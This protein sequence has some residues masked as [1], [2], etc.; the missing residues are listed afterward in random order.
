M[1][2]ESQTGQSEAVHTD[3]I[4]Q[5]VTKVRERLAGRRRVLATY[6]LQF[7]GAQFR[8][9][10]G[11][12][13]VD[14]LARLGISHVYSSPIL[15]AGEGSTHGY[16]VVDH[17][18]LNDELGTDEEY[19]AYVGAL[20]EHG[21]GQIL[22]IVPNH[23]SVA[24]DAN[25]WWRDVLANGPAS[26]YA[27]YFDIDWRPVKRELRNRVLLPVLGDLYGKTLEAGQLPILLEEG[28]FYVQVYQRKLPLE[29]RTWV[30]ILEPGMEALT[31]KLNA[32]SLPLLEL[33]SIIRGLSYLPACDETAPD[34]LEERR[35]EQVV[36]QA[37]LQRLFDES[38]EIKEFVEG[39]IRRI[40]GEPGKPET[41]EALDRLLESQV[42]R[43]VLWRAGSDELNYRRFFD[44]TELA[45]VCTEHLDV[46]EA[47]H[48]LPFELLLRGD[49]D[50][51]RIDHVDGLFDPTEYLWRLQWMLLR[52]VTKQEFEKIAPGQPEK[53]QEIKQAVLGRLRGDV[54]GPDPVRLIEKAP[55]GHLDGADDA[56]TG[57]HSSKAKPLFVL[58][59]KILGVDEPLPSHWPVEGTSGYDF[60]NLLNGLF[61]DPDGL[62]Q[63]E[64]SWIRYTD[65]EEDLKDIV[66]HSKRLILSAAMQSEV[67]LLAH[68]LDR[69][70][71]RHRNT[72]DYTLQAIRSAIREIIASFPVYRTYIRRGLISERDRRVVQLATA[73]A[74]RRNPA[75]DDS[76]LQFVRDVLLLEQPPTLDEAGII[77]RY[78][79]IGRFQQVSSPVMAKGVEDTAFYRYVPLLSLEE[80]G[81][82]PAHG[83]LSVS[84]FHRQNSARRQEWPNAMLATSTHDTKRSEDVRARLD[85]LSEIPGEW[86]KA[87]SRWTRINKKFHRDVDGEPAP[88]RND[89]WLFYQS[90]VGVWPLRPPGAEERKILVERLQRY[91]EKA[92]REEKLNTSWISPNAAYDE[93]V[94]SFVADVMNPANGRFWTDFTAFHETVVDSGLIN[95]ASQSALKLTAPGIPD[96]YQGQELWDF[97]LVDPDNRRPVDYELRKRLLDDLISR[98]RDAASRL[99]LCKELIADP[100]DD[101]FKLLVH[102][103]LLQLRKRHPQL[104]LEGDYLPLAVEGELAEH[105]IAFARRLRSSD[106]S[107]VIVAP[108]LIHRLRGPE[109]RSPIGREVW[110]ETQIVIGDALPSQIVNQFTGST[111]SVTN[112][113]L[114]VGEALEHFPV[115]ALTAATLPWQ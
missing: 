113:R 112:G 105:V 35:R 103:T 111:A 108:R 17:T 92:T 91:M 59:E 46:F 6:R 106:E 83:A 63:I 85:V 34:K 20:K 78:F 9:S 54:G 23:M 22:D 16:D 53:L 68:R 8:F 5:L 58:V 99:Q 27:H 45:A 3:L 77:E 114:A 56:T 55:G 72:R 40:N 86:Q 52:E 75:V 42:Y 74:R 107:V 15:K 37:R 18:R 41:F 102:F 36:L 60:L 115:A 90:L 100:R 25:H 44:V 97:S 21:L 98:S 10:Q 65:N 31:E 29:I 67:S 14:Y 64:R 104:F 47:T 19:E 94:Q 39:N 88:S 24:T 28:R 33:Q 48:R 101:R 70:S 51:F 110:G 38:P 76:V 96:V 26:P 43:L 82:E 73:H 69:L 57:P 11:R 1:S 89:E 49:I 87:V 93:A 81:G 12:E 109:R 71:N 95:A 80:V 2:S 66:Y 84:E 62:R 7:T 4:D 30:Q 61:V 13:I 79:F 32:E 50:G